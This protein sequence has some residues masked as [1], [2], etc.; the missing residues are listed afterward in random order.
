MDSSSLGGYQLIG[1]KSPFAVRRAHWA[2]FRK[3]ESR[4]ESVAEG[5][6]SSKTAGRTTSP[7]QLMYPAL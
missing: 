6:A 7:R 4:G 3:I 2:A 5:Y 1:C